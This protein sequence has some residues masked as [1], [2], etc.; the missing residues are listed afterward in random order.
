VRIEQADDLRRMAPVEPV[1]Q[2]E[3]F[4]SSSNRSRP[5]SISG[6][7][8]QAPAVPLICR[9]VVGSSPGDQG[10][11]AKVAFPRPRE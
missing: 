9:P 6:P 7:A 10:T 4:E 11:C 5:V 2:V 1:G 3:E 8:V